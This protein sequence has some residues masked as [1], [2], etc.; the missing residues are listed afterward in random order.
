MSDDQRP[1]GRR[2]FL[3][4]AGG[5]LTTT[6]AGCSSLLG[7]GSS[8]GDSSGGGTPNPTTV[9]RTRTAEP[10]ST[11]TTS[12]PST[13]T[14]TGTSTGQSNETDL[15]SLTAPPSTDLP[16]CVVN[17][18]CI[19]PSPERN[20]T[21]DPSLVGK[22]NIS[23]VDTS[24]LNTDLFSTT[25]SVSPTPTSYDGTVSVSVTPKRKQVQTTTDGGA[26]TRETDGMVCTV[27]KQTATTGGASVFL[28]NPS[29]TTVFPGAL[30][31]AESIA[32]GSF[33]PVLTQNRLNGARLA[34]VRNPLQLSISLANIDGTNTKTVQLP[35]IGSVRTARNQILDRVG[36]AKTPAAMDYQKH[37]IYSKRQ[38]DV[39]LGAHYHSAPV[40]VSGNYDFSQTNVTNKLLAKFWQKYYDI[41]ISLPNPVGDGVL[42]DS[43]YS[44]RNDVIV[45]NVSYGR[46][47]VFSLESKYTH[48]EVE[49]SLDVA[50]KA[51]LGGNGKFSLSTKDKQVLKDTK[52]HINVLGGSAS[53]ASKLISGY[54]D[55]G[56]AQAIGNWIQ[57]GATY[58]PADSPGAPI[59]YQTKYLNGLGTANVYLTTT[60]NKRSCHSKT[61]RYRV[62][63][64]DLKVVTANDVAG[65]KHTEEMYGTIFVGGAI[66]EKGASSGTPIIGTPVWQKGPKEWVRI[67]QGEIEPLNV[68]RT[69]EFTTEGELDRQR[70]Y[71]E[72][73][74]RPREHDGGPDDFQGANGVHR[75]FLSDDPSDPSKTG[76]GRGHLK[77]SFTDK[78]S[79]VEISF[80]IT[81]LP[82]K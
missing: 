37:R 22:L 2:A 34:D 33:T 16:P 40:N 29:V 18:T 66:F 81:P 75:W 69:V 38:L 68:D 14:T 27:R 67:R 62:H 49:T 7:G 35:S 55:T 13:G 32:D 20:V 43:N 28:L 44:R 58:S 76:L 21:F 11:T 64:F 9:T 59:A 46:V 45:N 19:G 1:V 52:I 10:T 3:A 26:S 78:G 36:S 48:Q 70:S 4:T 65:S 5:L 61:R 77:K 72:V 53:S 42:S 31:R 30:L 6:L 63:N 56:A 41:S 80:D 82:P 79:E 12:A 39:E 8:G 15:A 73:T 51:G 60:Y 23:L 24:L 17:G 57:R 25:T 47:L 50:V 54:G 71:I 74:M